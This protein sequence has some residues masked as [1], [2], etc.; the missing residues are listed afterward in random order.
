MT[1][2]KTDKHEYISALPKIDYYLQRVI[3]KSLI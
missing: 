2:V 1:L 3:N